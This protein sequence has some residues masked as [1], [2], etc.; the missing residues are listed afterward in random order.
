ML[1]LYTTGEMV[2]VESSQG[3]SAEQ[4]SSAS[5]YYWCFQVVVYG[6]IV[7]DWHID[8]L[9]I[10]QTIDRREKGFCINKEDFVI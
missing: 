1:L 10:S 6:D 7:R 5:F 4:C 3:F 2:S 9:T 8:L